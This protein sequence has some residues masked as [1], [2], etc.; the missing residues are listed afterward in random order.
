MDFSVD[1][2]KPLEAYGHDLTQMASRETF[3]PLAHDET[4][5]HK[6]FRS[7]LRKGT[8]GFNQ[9]LIDQSNQRR[10]Q[11]FQDLARRMLASDVP[12]SI[13]AKQLIVLR[14]EAIFVP[15]LLPLPVADPTHLTLEQRQ[16][17]FIARWTPELQQ[18]AQII[19][20]CL[21]AFLQA[22]KKPSWLRSITCTGFVDQM[23][24]VL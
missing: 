16:E 1:R 4:F 14:M 12:T 22:I 5:F 3:V 9:L 19:V 6:V 13:G 15:F 8:A 24:A 11:F 20:E 17:R 18:Q 10:S 2:Q 21:Q 7:L 23:S